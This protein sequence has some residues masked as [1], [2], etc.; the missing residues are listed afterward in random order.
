MSFPFIKKATEFGY[1]KIIEKDI[2]IDYT[3]DKHI[4]LSN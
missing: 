4:K 1:Y 2:K 3:R